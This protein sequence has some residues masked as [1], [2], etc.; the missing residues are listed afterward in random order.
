MFIIEVTQQHIF[1][2]LSEAKNPNILILFYFWIL[3]YTPLRSVSFRMTK[4]VTSVIIKNYKQRPKLILLK[5]FS[6]YV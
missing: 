2:I 1:V 6:L 3:H 5:P 4:C